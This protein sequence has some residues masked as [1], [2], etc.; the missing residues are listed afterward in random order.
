MIKN[1]KKSI[2]E[3]WTTLMKNKLQKRRTQNKKNK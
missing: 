1:K 2:C 3:K